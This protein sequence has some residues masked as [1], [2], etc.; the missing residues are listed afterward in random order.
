M[1]IVRAVT[2]IVLFFLS[3]TAFWG[4]T[5]LIANAHGNPWGM[6][7]L[8]LLAHT[9]FHSWL[10]PGVILFSA[11]GL[12]A[13][14][15]LWLTLRRAPHYGLWSALQ[16]FVLLGWLVVE[17]LLLRIVIWPHYLYGTL[18]LFLILFGFGLQHMTGARP[19]PPDHRQSTA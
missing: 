4:G 17:C 18:A 2:M 13:L 7:P 11:N 3:A 14:W 15:A 8:T 5:V 10:I 19:T 16:G 12:L 6:M 9:P 1:R